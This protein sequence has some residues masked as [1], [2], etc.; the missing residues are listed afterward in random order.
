MFVIFILMSYNITEN[1]RCTYIY[2]YIYTA[3]YICSIAGRLYQVFLNLFSK[4]IIAARPYKVLLML[5]KR[6]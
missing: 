1:A 4:N 3:L 6:V 5:L 2:M